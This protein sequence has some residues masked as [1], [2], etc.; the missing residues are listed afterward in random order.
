MPVPVPDGS[1][2]NQARKNRGMP[3]KECRL[4]S[5]LASSCFYGKNVF[6]KPQPRL[7]RAR[8]FPRMGGFFFSFRYR[9]FYVGKCSYQITQTVPEQGVAFRLSTCVDRWQA[10][11]PAG[12][13]H[14][15]DC[16]SNMNISKFE[17]RTLHVLAK[18][19]RIVLVRDGSGKVCAAECYT[20]EGFLLTD[21]TLAIF[22]KLRKKGL[23][24][25]VDGQPYLINWTGLENVRS[26]LDNQ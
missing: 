4:A 19:G 24:R 6:A 18:G 11:V 3:E 2:G 1:A 10:F 5:V 8:L 13:A 23:I 9:D 26:Q 15:D 16:I 25:S 7:T 14:S 17:Q 20:R 21:C 12:F 22:K